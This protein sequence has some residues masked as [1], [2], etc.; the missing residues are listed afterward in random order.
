M[1]KVKSPVLCRGCGQQ[2]RDSWLV[3]T[4]QYGG[5]VCSRRCDV[6]ACVELEQSMPGAQGY[7]MTER[8]LSPFA[9]ETI[10]RNWD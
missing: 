1:A 3:K 5:K 2:L 6:R 10:R 8:G 4:C 9:K 7:H